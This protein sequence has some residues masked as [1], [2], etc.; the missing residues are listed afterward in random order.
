FT[1]SA[2]LHRQLAQLAREHQASLFMV[3][4]AALAALLTRVG[5][6]EDIPL[7]C[8]IAG[9]TDHALQS[10][11]G[12]FVNTLVLRTHTGGNPSFTQLLA[13]VRTTDLNAYAH[14]E[15]PFERLVE[16]I[17]P[18]RSLSVHP[19]FQV[20]LSVHNEPPPVV[21]WPQLALEVLPVGLPVAKFD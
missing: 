20:M 7:G 15:L 12:F 9:R 2:T 3:L 18:T 21:Q 16:A 10:L 1:L 14:Q 5:A 6:G 8:P 17:N 11:V 4:Q 19:L 13:R